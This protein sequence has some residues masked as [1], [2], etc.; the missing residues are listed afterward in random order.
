MFL[1]VLYVY[2]LRQIDTSQMTP[3]EARYVGRISE[4]LLD[5]WHGSE[6]C[7]VQ[8]SAMGAIGK[9]NWPKKIRSFLAAKFRN[10]KYGQSF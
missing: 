5:V 1:A 3:Y 9:E 4:L 2:L 8:G 6:P 10:Q 7:C